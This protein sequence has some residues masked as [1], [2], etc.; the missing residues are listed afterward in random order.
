MV[1]KIWTK[2]VWR[3]KYEFGEILWGFFGKFQGLW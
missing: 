1:K 2:E 3:A